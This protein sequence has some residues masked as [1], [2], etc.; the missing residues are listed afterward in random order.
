MSSDEQYLLVEN[1]EVSL[2]LKVTFKFFVN[3]LALQDP[4]SNDSTSWTINLAPGESIVKK[5]HGAESKNRIGGD[6]SG[7]GGIMS[8]YDDVSREFKIL[9]SKVELY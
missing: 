7:M 3:G 2:S 4:D 1:E 8:M 6:M 5:F 9:K